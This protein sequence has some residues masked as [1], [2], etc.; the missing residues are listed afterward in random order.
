MKFK[1]PFERYTLIS[2]LSPEIIKERL[3]EQTS[4]SFVLNSKN[5]KTYSGEIAGNAFL[6][7]R[8]NE[9]KGRKRKSLMAIKGRITDNGAGSTIAM[10]MSFSFVVYMVTGLIFLI[11][12]AI[13]L[14]NNRISFA[15]PFSFGV[16]VIPIFFIIYSVSFQD[17]VKREKAYLS[18]LFE[19]IE[20]DL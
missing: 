8:I 20:T 6:I 19:G 18:E 2:P 17:D 9:T 5:M 3:R 16:I 13:A 11:S 4:G 7:T 12:A 15:H 1:L 10:T 14:S